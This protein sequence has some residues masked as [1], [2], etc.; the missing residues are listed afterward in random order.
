MDLASSRF[1]PT[2]A[3]TVN[4][5][6]TTPAPSAQ[7]REVSARFYEHLAGYVARRFPEDRAALIARAAY[8]RAERRGFSPGHEL[9]DWLAAED[10]ILQRLAGE[11][12][13]Y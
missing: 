10:E 4:S 2:A 1:E 7:T 5:A 9:D 12:R 13:T 3:P 6:D 8:F 11:G